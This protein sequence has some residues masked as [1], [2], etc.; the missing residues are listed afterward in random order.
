MLDNNAHVPDAHINW[1]DHLDRPHRVRRIGRPRAPRVLLDGAFEQ[2]FARTFVYNILFED[3]EVDE[4]FL[5]LDESSR[6]L[7][8]SGAGCGVAGMLSAN[9][10]S[11]DA[12]DVNKHHLALTGLKCAAARGSTEY[13]EFYDLFARGWSPDPW[14][15]IEPLLTHMPEW[16]ARYWSRHHDRFEENLYGEGLTA[17]MLAQVRRR[18]GIGRGWARAMIE[19][20]PNARRTI[21]DETLASANGRL[22]QAA[23]SSPLQ[24]LALGINFTQSDRIKQTEELSMTEFFKDHI[25]RV[26]ET[27]L[28]RN[29]FFWF[30]AAG[31]FNYAE[32]DAVPPYLRRDRW[33]RSRQCETK[34]RF[35]RRSMLDIMRT[36]GKSTWTHFAFLDATDWAPTKIQRLLFEEVRRTGTDGATLLLRSVEGVDPVEA[37]GADKW[38]ERLPCSDEAT[39]LD[40]SRQYRQVNFYRLHK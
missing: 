30:A 9:P 5:G 28:S 35:Q 31:H 33:E 37:T 3:A 21:L 7:A 25:R 17:K 16:M 23:M 29:W 10:R 4:R 2:V 14:A 18:L 19:A 27:D 32:P 1:H 6:V 11:I 13:Q 39:L 15:T 22:M 34:L 24:L 26:A 12:I 20:P 38:L 8:I 40:R 36:A